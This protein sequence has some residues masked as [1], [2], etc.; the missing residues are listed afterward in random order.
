MMLAYY[1]AE[2][3]KEINKLDSVDLM[4]LQ[5]KTKKEA[6]VFNNNENRGFYVRI[7]MLNLELEMIKAELNQRKVNR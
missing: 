1:L 4:I 6:E 3:E 5:D 7:H 2:V